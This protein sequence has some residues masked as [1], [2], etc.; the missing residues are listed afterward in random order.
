LEINFLN[1]IFEQGKSILNNQQ[2]VVMSSV[3][4]VI[5]LLVFVALPLQIF[6]QTLTGSPINGS[7]SYSSL[8][9]NQNTSES[10]GP[11]IKL[12]GTN[13]YGELSLN[14]FDFHGLNSSNPVRNAIN[15]RVGRVSGAPYNIGVLSLSGKL[16]LGPQTDIANIPSLG[17]GSSN[18]F[19]QAST[20]EGSWITLKG[21]WNANARNGIQFLGNDLNIFQSDDYS[22][23]FSTPDETEVFSFYS[24]F[25]ATRIRNAEIRV[26]GASANSYF[27]FLSLSYVVPTTNALGYGK[28]AT[29]EGNI[30]LM[31]GI[32]YPGGNYVGINTINPLANLHVA[33]PPGPNSIPVKVLIGDKAPFGEFATSYKLAVEGTGVFQAVAVTEQSAWADFVFEPTYKLPELKTVESFIAKNGHL[34]EIPSEKEVKEKGYQLANMDA[35]LLQKIE[36]LTLYII[37][38]QKQVDAL[39]AG[40]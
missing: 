7:Q 11:H 29:D 33:T 31:P 20:N 34:P 36:E 28:L 2:I 6:A 17:A 24:K 19:L 8:D 13:G 3:K 37:D 14:A 30:I 35:K 18:L 27:K 5:L 25:N 9:I 4:N 22:Q 26:H 15:F 32:N 1:I 16:W 21:D 10:N 23:G 39:K 38:L 40:K 12:N